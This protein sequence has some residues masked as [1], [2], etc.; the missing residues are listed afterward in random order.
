MAAADTEALRQDLGEGRHGGGPALPRR[1]MH[2]GHL[3]IP[4]SNAMLE[5]G[6]S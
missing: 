1:A 5:G 6:L 4:M 2:R 3:K